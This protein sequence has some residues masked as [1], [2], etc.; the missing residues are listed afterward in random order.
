MTAARYNRGVPGPVH[1]DSNPPIK[2]VAFPCKPLPPD[3]GISSVRYYSSGQLKDLFKSLP[4]E[5]P[6]EFFTANPPGAISQDLLSLELGTMT[7]HPI[8]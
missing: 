7:P 1:L 8:R 4:D 3:I 5:E 6:T 2:Y